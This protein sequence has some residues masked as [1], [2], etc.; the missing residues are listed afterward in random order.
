MI[1]LPLT[2]LA[3]SPLCNSGKMPPA[4]PQEAYD[5]LGVAADEIKKDPESSVLMA[6]SVRL[7]KNKAKKLLQCKINE[8]MFDALEREYY[9]R[10]SITKNKQE[11]NMLGKYFRKAM[12]PLLPFSR[13]D[14][15]DPELSL[16]R[17][18]MTRAEKIE[19]QKLSA[20]IATKGF[21]RVSL[22]KA[23]SNEDRRKDP[24]QPIPAKAIPTPDR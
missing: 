5:Q 17:I 6:A 3:L 22:K 19:S 4:M 12:E 20:L 18:H 24:S 8:Y 10:S 14:G 9:Y 2:A 21:G 11:I 1:E 7:L 16:R 15:S 23:K 13:K